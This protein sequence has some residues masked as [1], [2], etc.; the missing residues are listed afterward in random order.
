MFDYTKDCIPDE[1]KS[2]FTFSYEIHWWTRFSKVFHVPK[3]NATQ[4]GI[5]ITA[6]QVLFWTAK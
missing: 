2:L 3:R 1:L 6:G 5:N 4:F